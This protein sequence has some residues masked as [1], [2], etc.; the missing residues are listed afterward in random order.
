MSAKLL[1]DIEGFLQSTGMS[2]FRF[3]LLAA[4]NGRLVERLRKPRPNGLPARV[5]PETEAEIRAFMRVESSRRRA[6]PLQNE[7]K[8]A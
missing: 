7:G 4:R 8:A 6:K 1:A 2:A 3:G 5:W